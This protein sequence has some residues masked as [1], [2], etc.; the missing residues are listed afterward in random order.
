MWD[1][2]TGGANCRFF[3]K[4]L[5]KHSEVYATVMN[6]LWYYINHV[7]GIYIRSAKQDDNYGASNII[8]PCPGS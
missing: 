4:D 8:L 1:D 2:L 5:K 6:K 7:Q 3:A